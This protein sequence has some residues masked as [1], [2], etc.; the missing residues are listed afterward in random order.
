MSWW[1]ALFLLGNVLFLLYLLG[2]SAALQEH[3]KA[4]LAYHDQVKA[5]HA[6]AIENALAEAVRISTIG[7]GRK[8]THPH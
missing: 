6:S 3:S 8:T 5:M 4:V 1:N 2:R 7:S